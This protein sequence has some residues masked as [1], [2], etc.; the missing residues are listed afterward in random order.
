MP[1]LLKWGYFVNPLAIVLFVTLASP[2]VFGQI[3]IDGRTRT[4]SPGSAGI[5]TNTQNVGTAEVLGTSRFRDGG[6]FFDYMLCNEGVIASASV[7]GEY[8]RLNN[9]NRIEEASVSGRNALLANAVVRDPPP[10][11][12][13]TAIGSMGTVT[14]TDQAG[15]RNGDPCSIDSV[16]IDG[17]SRL[18]NQLGS[19]DTLTVGSNTGIFANTVMHNYVSNRGQIGN[20]TMNGGN[21]YNGG[22][23]DNLTYTGGTYYGYTDNGKDM[24]APVGVTF[25]GSIG[26]LTLADNATGIIWGDVDELVFDS[27]GDGILSIAALGMQTRSGTPSVS[28]EGINAGS[29]DLTYGNIALDLTGLD[30]LGDDLA[31]VFFSAFGADGFS[32][33]ALFGG[34]DVTEA[35]EDIKSFQIAWG[36]DSFFI[37]NGYGGVFEEG[38][39][40]DSVTGFVSWN[41]ATGDGN[42]VPEPATL[43]LIGLGLAGLGLARRRRK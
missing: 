23:V 35:V 7:V 38:W 24:A 9:Y 11:G 25:I 1:I 40:F 31:S 42:V 43:T 15:L 5:V 41:E 20:F 4:P 26:K 33:S 36:S 34:A 32:L 8:A 21:V 17:G 13:Y 10:D 22:T 18:W 6:N 19:I 30:F 2:A 29:V 14:V 16:S 27:N 39:N 3:R 28:F 12:G 37:L